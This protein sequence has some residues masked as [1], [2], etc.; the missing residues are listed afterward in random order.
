[1]PPLYFED[2]YRRLLLH[3]RQRVRAGELTERGLARLTGLSQPHLHNVL[4]GARRLS[5]PLADQ[6]LRRLRLSLLDLLTA[7]ERAACPQAYA[8]APAVGAPQP[9]R[10]RRRA[11][12]W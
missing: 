8:P 1:M 5:A 11:T 10:G 9:R 4:K 2:L 7:E 3:L 6:L 12:S